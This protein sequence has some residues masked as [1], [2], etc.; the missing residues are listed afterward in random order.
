MGRFP[1]TV[2]CSSSRC[3][4][5]GRTSTDGSQNNSESHTPGCH[6]AAT[7]TC[8]AATPA[9]R[10]CQRRSRAAAAS[11]RSATPRRTALIRSVRGLADGSVSDTSRRW[12]AR[13]GTAAIKVTARNP[14]RRPASAGDRWN[15]STQLWSCHKLMLTNPRSGRHVALKPLPS[16]SN[17]KT[18]ST[19]GPCSCTCLDPIGRVSRPNGR[20]HRAVQDEAGKMS[21]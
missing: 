12:S 1:P 17:T 11:R 3:S 4:V 13:C 10:P 9:G 2:E 7:R 5:D 15:V 8:G 14:T 18:R 20:S 19:V 21:P 6:S 16:S